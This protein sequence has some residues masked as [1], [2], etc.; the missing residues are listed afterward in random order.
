MFP[1]LALLTLV[2]LAA[3]GIRAIGRP[4]DAK[5]VFYSSTILRNSLA[6]IAKMQEPELR[7]FAHYIAECDDT[8]NASARHA[9]SAAEVSY[10]IEFGAKRALDDMMLARSTLQT[11]S[12]AEPVSPAVHQLLKE[13]TILEALQD[14]ARLR[15]QALRSSGGK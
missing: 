15:F 9:C 4:F 7:A 3:P 1:R 11:M 10:N 12:I 13:A 2:L 14:A 8:E 6:D 5:A